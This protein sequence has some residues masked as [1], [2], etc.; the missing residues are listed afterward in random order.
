[1]AGVELFFSGL[2]WCLFGLG[3]ASCLIPRCFKAA[4]VIMLAGDVALM[5]GI[6]F[7]RMFMGLGFFSSGDLTAHFYRGAGIAAAVALYALIMYPRWRRSRRSQA[8][9][10]PAASESSSAS[11]FAH[12]APGLFASVKK[13]AAKAA[14][15]GA[16]L[17]DGV[18]PKDR[19]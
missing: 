9:N 10:T 16:S 4:V 6:L 19:P 17:F 5:L 12:A 15:S 1:M 13:P 2:G 8:A 18:N 11:G 3:L 7:P 14:S